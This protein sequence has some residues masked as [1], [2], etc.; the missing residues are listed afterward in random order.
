MWKSSLGAVYADKTWGVVKWV[1]HRW[2]D[3]IGMQSSFV[4]RG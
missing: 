1:F 3:L 4:K 2:K